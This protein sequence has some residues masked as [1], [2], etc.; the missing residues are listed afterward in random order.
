VRVRKERDEGRR[1][2]KEGSHVGEMTPGGLAKG[3]HEEEEEEEE[4][5][6]KEAW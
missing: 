2:V 6:I 4:E 3:R 1:G 5:D